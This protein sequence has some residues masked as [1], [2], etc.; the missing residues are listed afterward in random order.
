MEKL[1]CDVETRFSKNKHCSD[2]IILIKWFYFRP[3]SCIFTPEAQTALLLSYFFVCF[4]MPGLCD[5]H[6]EHH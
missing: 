5:P 6:Q 4:L 2:E 1:V 3:R